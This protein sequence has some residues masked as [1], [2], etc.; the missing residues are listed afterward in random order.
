MKN[1]DASVRSTNVFYGLQCA[2]ERSSS[3]PSVSWIQAAGGARAEKGASDQWIVLNSAATDVMRLSL[4]SAGSA[5]VGSS[6][7]RTAPTR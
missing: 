3:G 1:G 5:K 2:G 4:K 7:A 6:A